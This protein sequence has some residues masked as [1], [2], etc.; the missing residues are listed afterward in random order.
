M[1]LIDYIRRKIQHVL[2][3]LISFNLL[4][5]VSCRKSEYN[6]VDQPAYLRVFN[7]LKYKV[8][9][10]TKGKPVPFLI[11]I[12]DPEFDSNNTLIG[13]KVKG[14]FLDV[15]NKYSSPTANAASSDY[16]NKEYP[17]SL[18]IPVA[19]VINGFDLSNWAQVPSGTHR[20]IFCTR[21]QN[22]IPFFELPEKTRKEQIILADTTLELIQGEVYTM[23]LLEK[24]YNAD[25]LV[26]NV[27]LRKEIFQKLAFSDSMNYV[28]FYNLSSNGFVE[29]HPEGNESDGTGAGTGT[30]IKNEVNLFF[31]LLKN[32][33]G[34]PFTIIN[35]E[36]PRLGENLVEGYQDIPL[37]TLRRSQDPEVTPYNIIPLFVGRDTSNRT[38]STYWMKL[39]VV[40][41]GGGVGVQGEGKSPAEGMV[42]CLS[43]FSDEGRYIPSYL[44]GFYLPSIIRQVATGKHKQ[45]S[46]PTI[47][48]IE[49]INKEIYMTSVMKVYPAPEL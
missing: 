46:L 40:P 42:L 39:K 32:D 12:I 15:R 6:F 22:A 49:F 34:F 47:S 27:Y 2:L 37:K 36:R 20:F 23:N 38:M 11:M 35:N 5:I 4:F 3:F 7:T 33:V 8:D 14:D 45:K 18:K 24:E 17:G 28:N 29:A 25:K 1:K 30:A 16:K 13:G 19:P 9:L 10:S 26:T 31:S 41:P 21:P 48:S 43:N 44:N